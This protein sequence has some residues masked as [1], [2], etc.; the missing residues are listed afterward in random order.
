MAMLA[1]KMEED[2]PSH[3]SHLKR[4]LLSEVVSQVVAAAQPHYADGS[5]SGNVFDLNDFRETVSAD[6]LDEES[7]RLDAW[8]ASF[9]SFNDGHA[10]ERVARLVNSSGALTGKTAKVNLIIS[11][12]LSPGEQWADHEARAKYLKIDEDSRGSRKQPPLKLVHSENSTRL[13]TE[14]W[15]GSFSKE[16]HILG[17][18]HFPRPP[19]LLEVFQTHYKR[20]DTGQYT[21][22]PTALDIQ[23]WS[24]FHKP[25]SGQTMYT[26]YDHLNQC[27]ADERYASEEMKQPPAEELDLQSGVMSIENYHCAEAERLKNWYSGNRGLGHNWDRKVSRHDLWWNDTDD[28]RYQVWL[29]D[30]EVHNY[31]SLAPIVVDWTLIHPSKKPAAGFIYS[32]YLQGRYK[33]RACEQVLSNIYKASERAWTQDM[34]EMLEED[35]RDEPLRSLPI[36]H[37]SAGKPYG[38]S[39]IEY[40]LSQVVD[41]PVAKNKQ[42]LVIA[43]EHN[44]CK[45][46]MDAANDVLDMSAELSSKLD[47]YEKHADMYDMPQRPYRVRVNEHI[48]FKRPSSQ[49]KVDLKGGE[50]DSASISGFAVVNG[51]LRPDHIEEVVITT[52]VPTG[53]EMM[54]DMVWCKVTKMYMPTTYMPSMLDR[55]KQGIEDIYDAI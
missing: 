47:D 45:V 43:P 25:G 32:G 52:R 6:P 55:V 39:G 21:D 15:I 1:K 7:K 19:T 34:I 29:A 48:D 37:S 36:L 51:V 41:T 12:K 50:V 8:L 46:D 24:L 33:H 26:F 4:N 54:D 10:P 14:D 17:F 3:L 22:Q 20:L 38:D 2:I 40:L 5:A 35:L 13:K 16:G 11:T 53:S 9:A 42:L 28:R 18:L 23:G 30:R 31:R 44:P 49:N 27:Y